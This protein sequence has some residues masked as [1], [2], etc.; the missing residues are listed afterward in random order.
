VSKSKGTSNQDIGRPGPWGEN[1]YQQ[2]GKS[3]DNR[4]DDARQDPKTKS[5]DTK[6]RPVTLD[7][8]TKKPG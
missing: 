5:K 8:Y 3:V 2:P 1:R 6:S 4:V 7:D